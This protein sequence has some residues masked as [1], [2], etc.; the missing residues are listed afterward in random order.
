MADATMTS[1]NRRVAAVEAQQP[2][3]T[4]WASVP[5]IDDRALA[6]ARLQGS[7]DA[8]IRGPLTEQHLLRLAERIADDAATAHDTE[9]LDAFDRDDLVITGTTAAYI[10]VARASIFGDISDPLAH[11]EDDDAT[12]IPLAA[13]AIRHAADVLR[14]RMALLPAPEELSRIGA[15][16]RSNT[17]TADDVV[18]VRA[19][20]GQPL[21]A[22]AS[23]ADYPVF[24]GYRL[25]DF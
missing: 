5:V 24:V 19:M 10:V 14:V 25:W 23:Q 7:L 8:A 15:A 2:A 4:G 12:V 22:S 21:R 1:L 17:H 9:L 6:L 13:A 11:G 20:P 16:L 3:R 18:V